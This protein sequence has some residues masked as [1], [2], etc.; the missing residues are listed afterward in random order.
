MQNGRQQVCFAAWKSKVKLQSIL[1]EYFIFLA[2]LT[3]KFNGIFKEHQKRALIITYW[4]KR[5]FWQLLTCVLHHKHLIKYLN[6]RFIKT[7]S[8][9][10]IFNKQNSI[11]WHILV[12]LCL[13]PVQNKVQ[14]ILWQTSSLECIT[15]S[16]KCSLLCLTKNTQIIVYATREVIAMKIEQLICQ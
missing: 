9:N 13:K 15:Q 1:K 2:T 14:K 10:L 4:I 8:Q 3:G 6:K 5:T 16:T 11:L 12:Q 7:V